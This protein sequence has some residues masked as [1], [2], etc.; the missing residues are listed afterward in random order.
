[1]AKVADGRR[2][3]IAERTG[4]LQITLVTPCAP[5]V[6]CLALAVIPGSD[7]VLVIGEKTER[8]TGNRCR[9]R[10]QTHGAKT[11]AITGVQGV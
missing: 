1:M 8:A 11:T 9:E 2:V 4:R 6:I 5:V 3:P 10:S 7:N